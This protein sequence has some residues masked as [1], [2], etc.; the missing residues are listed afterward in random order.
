MKDLSILVSKIKQKAERLARRN[1]LLEEENEKIVKQLEK[2]KEELKNKDQQVTKLE[3]KVRLLK[4]AKSVDGVS[5]KEV[6]LR[7]N[8]MV[9]EIDKCIA[10]INR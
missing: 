9:R 2:I 5:T 4:I 10:Q 1:T 6:K 3:D 8:E 7:V